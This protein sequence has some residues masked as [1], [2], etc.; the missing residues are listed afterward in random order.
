DWT[1]RLTLLLQVADREMVARELRECNR[2]HMALANMDNP[3]FWEGFSHYDTF[4][5]HR[6]TSLD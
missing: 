3:G 4:W 2:L 1:L 6:K 5:D